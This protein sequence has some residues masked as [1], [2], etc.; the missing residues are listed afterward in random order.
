V[1]AF[2]N[3]A[4]LSGVMAEFHRL[5]ENA[6]GSQ[7]TFSDAQIQAKYVALRSR[8][9]G[10]VQ[11]TVE[12]IAS[13]RL[14]AVGGPTALAESEILATAL[15]RVRSVMQEVA[16]ISTLSDPSGDPLEVSASNIAAT[17]VDYQL[18]VLFA[19][20][21]TEA[22]YADAAQGGWA[23][24]AGRQL[25]AEAPLL[26]QLPSHCRSRVGHTI[27]ARQACS[28]ARRLSRA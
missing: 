16:R 6:G 26:W 1:G 23:A 2:K 27:A 25:A 22:Q 28:K 5:R 24:Y 3:G 12:D 7:I 15:E 13:V 18:A 14:L 21:N 8:F 17:G 20:R 9:G 10:G 4:N 11:P 19:S